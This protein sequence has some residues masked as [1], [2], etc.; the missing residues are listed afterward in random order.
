MHWILDTFSACC[1]CL[2]VL[3]AHEWYIRAGN[4]PFVKHNFTLVVVAIVAVSVLPVVFEVRCY[5]AEL[6]FIKT[7]AMK[8]LPKKPLTVRLLPLGPQVFA[9][10]REAA[11]SPQSGKDIG[12]AMP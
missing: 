12:T 2:D 11:A 1:Q 7:G 3:A 9:A 6:H 10:R 5:F 8:R 4:F